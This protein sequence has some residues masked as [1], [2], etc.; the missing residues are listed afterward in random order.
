MLCS[1][2]LLFSEGVSSHEFSEKL[3]V[4]SSKS[5]SLTN[6]ELLKLKVYFIENPTTRL[7]QEKHD[8]RIE[9]EKLD[10]YYMAVIKPINALNVRNDLLLVL[11]P[12]FHDIFFIDY[13]KQS[14]ETHE[15]VT[16]TK[17]VNTI[18]Q[19]KKQVSF[20]DEIGLQWLAL[21]GLSAVGLLLS[22]LSRRKIINLGKRQKDL[23]VEQK[24]IEKEIKK[25]GAADA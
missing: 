21:L 12:M 3:I 22:I 16:V 10:N 7:L 6:A 13:K 1:I 19:E 4:S 9:M 17:P 5:K 14:V 20:M 15:S 24:K 2:T 23:K 11:T 8:L 18:L 25:L